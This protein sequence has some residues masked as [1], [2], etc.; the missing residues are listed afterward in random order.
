MAMINILDRKLLSAIFDMSIVSIEHIPELFA[1]STLKHSQ[2]DIRG[3]M[4]GPGGEDH[5][6]CLALMR[7]IQ[8]SESLTKIIVAVHAETFVPRLCHLHQQ[9]KAIENERGV[10]ISYGKGVTPAS[11]RILLGILSDIEVTSKGQAGAA[12]MLE[13]LFNHAVRSIAQCNNGMPFDERTIFQITEH[14]FDLVAFSPAI[15][16]NLFVDGKS[17]SNESATACLECLTTTCITG[18]KHLSS[19]ELP[20]AA[21]MQVSQIFPHPLF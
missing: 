1:E 12:S 14:T 7:L 3:T 16:V 19:S 2:Y 20:S 5:V 17:S 4:R 13:E 9:L 6:G 15:L 11:R 8:E 18:Y 21:I 10:G